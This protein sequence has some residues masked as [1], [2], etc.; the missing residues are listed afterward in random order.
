MKSNQLKPK[1]SETGHQ[2]FLPIVLRGCA[3]QLAA[4]IA[5]ED[6]EKTES[7]KVMTVL[8]HLIKS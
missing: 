5:N 7:I 1:F 8:T 3:V 4:N 6:S 2:R